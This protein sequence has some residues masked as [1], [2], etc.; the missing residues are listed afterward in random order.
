MRMR[1]S[2]LSALILSMTLSGS[3]LAA[4]GTVLP[5]TPSAAAKSSTLTSP[6]VVED[7]CQKIGSDVSALIDK[8]ANSPNISAARA[9]F[10]VGIMECMDGDDKAA[11]RHYQ[12]AQNL[13]SSDRQKA[14]QV[15]K[16]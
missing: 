15:P 6:A 9:I 12:E 3:L 16:P 2:V 8:T 4:P 10:Q 7:D 1:E 14:V 5:T 13:L 11:N